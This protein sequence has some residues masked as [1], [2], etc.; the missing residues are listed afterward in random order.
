MSKNLESIIL[1][2]VLALTLVFSS[3]LIATAQDQQFRL[4]FSTVSVPKDPHSQAIEKFAQYIEE[5]TD[6]QIKVDVFLQG[7]LYSQE[8]VR[9]AIRRGTVAMTYTAPNWL[10]Q[11][12]PYMKMFTSGYLYSGYDH[13]RKVWGGPIGR[14]VFDDVAEKTGVRPLASYYLGTRNLNLK[15][16]A[17]V[18]KTPEDL[19]GVKLRMPNT[20]SWLFLGKALGA[21]PTPISFTELY[22][23]LNT[24]TVQGQENP[25]PTDKNAKFYEV[26][27]YIVLTEHYISPVW[28]AINEEI[29]DQMSPDLQAKMYQAAEKARKWM[30]KQVLQQEKELLSFF[31]EQGLEIIEPDKEAFKKHVVNMYMENE[32]LTKDWN[33]DLYE[34][35]QELAS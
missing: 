31:E 13:Y 10:T 33:M 7:K 19:K 25:L 32:K 34:A 16:N 30:D 9:T 15:K 18:V 28:P 17:G 8:A 20:E 14:T 35:V 3:V 5:M 6:G 22:T 29:W 23:A 26:T 12:M 24:G 1:I 4:R 27:H 11:E 2:T 21:K